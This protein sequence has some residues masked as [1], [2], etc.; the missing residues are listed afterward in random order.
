MFDKE[1]VYDMGAKERRERERQA[2]REGILV[3]ARQIAQN[4]GW[5]S[6]TIRKVAEYIEY[7][8]SMVY[9]YFPSKEAILLELFRQGFH[10]LHRDLQ[11]AAR[12][13]VDPAL[14]PERMAMAYWQFARSNPELYQ[15]M[16]SVG[17]VALQAE[18]QQDTVQVVCECVQSAL[19][20]WAQASGVTLADPFR[21]TELAWC[22]LHGLVSAY[23][24]GRIVGGE[25]A[26]EQQ[27]TRM[28]RT[29]LAGWAAT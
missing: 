25:G 28:I 15:V 5:L 13:T 3:G 9:E 22:A 20:D 18:A 19:E 10:Q 2:T 14:R 26:A 1:T 21:A 23:L 16:H 6:V 7:S 4:E 11:D 12:S 24:T 27:V 17:G 8:P 29:L